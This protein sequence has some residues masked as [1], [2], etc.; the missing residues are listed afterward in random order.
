MNSSKLRRQIA[1]DAARLM[2]QRDEKEYFRAKMKAAARLSNSRVK[3]SDLPSNAE[4]REQILILSQILEGDSRLDSLFQMRLEGLRMMRMMARFKPRLIGSVL[5]GHIRKGSDIDIHLFSDSLSAVTAELDFH[6]CHYDIEFKQATKA[7]TMQTYRHVHV[8]DRFEFELTVYPLSRSNEMFRSSITGKPIE[9]AN[10]KQLEQFL[11]ESYPETDLTS[12]LIAC[13]NKIDPYQVFYSLL[14]PLENV[15]QNPIYHP[16]GDVL[17][18]SLQVFD[19]G[20]DR[21]PYDEEFLTAALL[22]DVGKGIDPYD[23]VGSG[24]EALQGLITPRTAWLIEHHMLTHQIHDRSIGHRT[25]Q[26]L[27]ANENYEDLLLLG[28]CDRGGRK[29][30]IS[31]TTLEA[32]IDYLRNIDQMWG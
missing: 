12:E 10:L 27:K 24:L 22:H 13:E 23:H 16:E 5:T 31:T 20:C 14:L 29:R 26:R 11:T 19:L 30:G 9:K 6:G 2:Y 32:A 3:P 18:H 25:W 1:Y 8:Y 4:I 15:K 21:A 7:G 28:E 17:Y